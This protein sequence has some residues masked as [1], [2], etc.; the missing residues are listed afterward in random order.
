MYNYAQ[1]SLK[2]VQVYQG[3]TNMKSKIV[4]PYAPILVES[5]RSIGYSFESALADIIDNSLG[6]G[7]TDINVF[8]SSMYPQYV[9]VVDNG[10]GMTEEEL[11]AA[12]RYGSKSS[13]DIRDQDDLGRFGLGLKTA[14]LSQCRKLTV[15]TKKDGTINA[16]CWDLDHIIEKCDWSLLCFAGK[17]ARSLPFADKIASYDSG[18]VV[19]WQI[20]DRITDSAANIQKVFDEKIEHARNHVAL[21]FH[22]FLDNDIINKRIKIA[23]NN[24]PVE[25]IDPFLTSNPATQPLTEQTI[26]IDGSAI[27][28]KPYILPYASK[29]SAKD[30]KKL[31]ELCDLRS[32][33]G[34]YIYR[35]KR[36]IIWGTWFRLIKSQE[37]NK[38]ARIRVDIPNTLDSI[39]EI[40]I[41]KSTASLPD[42]IKRN[43]VAIV[44]N[45]VGRSE[46]VYK[47]RGRSTSKDSLQHVWETIDNRGKFSYQI[48]RDLPIYKV[49]EDSLNERCRF[50]LD[51]FVKTL[52]DSFPY[53]DVYYRLAKDENAVDHTGM[54]F[55]EV[56]K[57]AEDM[58]AAY[59]EMGGD[60]KL[61]IETMDKIDYFVKYPDVVKKVREDYE[62][63]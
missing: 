23:F 12:M 63:D 16:A 54:D 15:I 36:L 56:Y 41:K 58:I 55:E 26:R 11:E 8:F 57:V 44:D 52:E 33:Q 9:A 50:Y 1:N 60:V 62:D 25:P 31:G 2:R 17:E 19:V 37:L 47:Y 7:A 39:W 22:R 4:L 32:N 24:A 29:V 40:D 10:V 30:K 18:T 28:V 49:L 46:H 51:S 3:E 42:V 13:L 27:K 35:N 53:G 38:L 45:S 14:S 34:F 59:K 21:V 43:L 48:N 61:F 6:K 20:F 5:T